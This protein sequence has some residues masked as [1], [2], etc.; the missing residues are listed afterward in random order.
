VKLIDRPNESNIPF[1]LFTF[2]FTAIA[3]G[4][5]KLTK[6]EVLTYW[7]ADK[8][9]NLKGKDVLQHTGGDTILCSRTLTL[10]DSLHRLG[11]D[12]VI[13]Y[14]VAYPG[15][16]GSGKCQMG[17]Y[18]VHS[19]VIWKHNNQTYAQRLEGKCHSTLYKID[20]AG[21]FDYYNKNFTT[22]T[23]E[24]FMPIIL[25]A[26]LSDDKIVKYTLI[27]SN[28]EP[29]YSIIYKD[30]HAF[31][32]IEFSK[33]EVEDKKSLFHDHNLSLKSYTWWEIIKRDLKQ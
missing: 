18:P 30:G 13:V 19:S 26:E 23:S 12:S 3:S 27:Y 28:H 6:E 8:S 21:I 2:F 31:K 17:S 22:I 11:I 5:K 15:Y 29:N 24:Y 25:D 10:I 33:S 14:T 16:S 4:Q 1:I 9:E 7:T 32:E 20:S